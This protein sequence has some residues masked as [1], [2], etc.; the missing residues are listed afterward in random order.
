MTSN[1]QRMKDVPKEIVSDEIQQN[2]MK[3]RKNQIN[4]TIVAKVQGKSVH[5]WRLPLLVDKVEEQNRKDA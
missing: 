5:E 3:M 4:R 2:F 1:M